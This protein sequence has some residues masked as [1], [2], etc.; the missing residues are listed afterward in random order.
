MAEPFPLMKLPPELRNCIY[1]AVVTNERIGIKRTRPTSIFRTHGFDPQ[2]FISS[3]RIVLANKEVSCEYGSVLKRLILDP[4]ATDIMIE[5]DWVDMRTIILELKSSL[6]RCSPDHRCLIMSKL[7]LR[8]VLTESDAVTNCLKG[9][10]EGLWGWSAFC[11]ANNVT[12]EY[13][14]LGSRSKI[15]EVWEFLDRTRKYDESQ[16]D[17]IGKEHAKI[18]RVLENASH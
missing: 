1:E 9:G 17:R 3:S 13:E 10:E 16:G 18:L 5:E 8:V 6:R 14:F 7:K 12:A 2:S 15:A 11:E 4:K